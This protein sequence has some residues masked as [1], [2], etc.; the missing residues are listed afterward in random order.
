MTSSSVDPELLGTLDPGKTNGR[1]CHEDKLACSIRKIGNWYEV[2]LY[3]RL[4][5]LAHHCIVALE[6]PLIGVKVEQVQK[7]VAVTH[8]SPRV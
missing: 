8:V 5:M 7:R 1:S 2:K 3:P 6:L 4:E